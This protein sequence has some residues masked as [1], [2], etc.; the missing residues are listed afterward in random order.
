MLNG[1]RVP[2][3]SFEHKTGQAPQTA[4]EAGDIVAQNHYTSKRKRRPKSSN[5]V[6]HTQ[7]TMAALRQREAEAKKPASK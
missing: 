5:R 1:D 3:H 4:S 7:A 6:D 2:G